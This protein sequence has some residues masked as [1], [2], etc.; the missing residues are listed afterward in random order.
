M[1]IFAF[2]I[3]PE[4]VGLR[5]FL[6][7]RQIL[8]GFIDSVTKPLEWKSLVSSCCR[9]CCWAFHGLQLTVPYSSIPTLPSG[10][11]DQCI[12]SIHSRYAGNLTPCIRIMQSFIYLLE[13]LWRLTACLSLFSFCVLTTSIFFLFLLFASLLFAWFFLFLLKNLME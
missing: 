2:F 7:K 12:W 8:Q 4:L 10:Q 13:C 11:C 3:V 6:K 9:A 1:L 5:I